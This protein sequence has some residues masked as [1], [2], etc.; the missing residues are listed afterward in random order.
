[1]D[2]QLAGKTAFVTGGSKGIGKAVA[3]A[4]SEEGVRVALMARTPDTTIAAAKEIEAATG[5][6]VLAVPGDTTRPDQIENAV[7]LTA[8]TYGSVDILVSNAGV[9]GGIGF[10][11]LASVSD[12][13]VMKDIETKFLGTL[14]CARAAVPYMQRNRWGRIIGIVGL[15]A[16]YASRYKS[17]RNKNAAFNYSGG[18]RNVAVIHLMRTLSHELGGDGITANAVLPGATRTEDLDAMLER[19]AQAKGLDVEEL[20]R[21]RVPDNAIQRWVTAQELADVVT[22]LASPRSA[23]ISGELIAASGGAGLGVF[24]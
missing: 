4:L 18:P 5:N 21:V 2:L 20:R 6:A 10:G 3:R 16:R 22:F 7:Q 8:D 15:S 11:P 23:S 14:R 24:S 9:P 13:N 1:M 12:E 17:K 19:H